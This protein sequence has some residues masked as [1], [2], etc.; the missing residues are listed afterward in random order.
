MGVFIIVMMVLLLSAIER[1][2]A[3]MSSTNYQIRASSLNGGGNLPAST[4]DGTGN[5]SF[6]LGTTLGQ[7]TSIGESSSI[8]NSSMNGFW[9]TSALSDTDSDGI[10]DGYGTNFCTGGNTVGCDDNCPDAPNPDQADQD[11]DGVGNVCDPDDDN[12]G[13]SDDDEITTYNTNPLLFDTDSD[14]YSDG[15]EVA[16]LSDPLDSQSTP[17]FATGDVAP[18]GAPDGVVDVADAMVVMRIAA[19]LISPEQLDLARA[20]VTPLGNPDGVVD[21]SDALMI[22]KKASGLP[23]F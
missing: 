11:G 8:I 16:L 6:I 15:E 23:S 17:E 4:D 19:G 20:D 10:P 1:G 13:L 5:G 21:I 7:S 18:H 3:V 2:S 14:G 12:D 9:Y 22:L